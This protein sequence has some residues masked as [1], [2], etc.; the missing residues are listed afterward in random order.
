MTNVMARSGQIA[1]QFRIILIIMIGDALEEDVH[2]VTSLE[3]TKEG[4]VYRSFVNVMKSLPDASR[5]ITKRIMVSFLVQNNL[6]DFYSL[7]LKL[8]F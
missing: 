5:D 2:C 8:F 1:F 6:Q 7:Q 4:I 3:Q